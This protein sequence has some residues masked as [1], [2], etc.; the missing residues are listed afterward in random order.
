MARV[1]VVGGGFGG[2]RVVHELQ[3]S[4][5]PVEITLVDRKSYFEV[6]YATLRTLTNPSFAGGTQRKAFDEF[7]QASFIQGEVTALVDQSATLA[8]G[9]EIP[10][11]FAVIATGTSYPSLP[12]AKSETALTLET[13]IAE[14]DTHHQCLEGYRQIQIVGAGAVGTELAAEIRA[15][16]PDKQVRLLD[17]GDRVLSHLQPKASA[18]AHQML[19][20]LG[21]DVRLNTKADRS[22]DAGDEHTYWCGGPKVQTGF[23]DGLSARRD[24]GLMKVD[25]YLRVTGHDNWFAVG[26]IVDLPDAKMGA[27]ASNQGQSVAGNLQRLLSVKK[28]LKPYK[29]QP[30]MSIV[31]IG[32]MK[33]VAQIGRFVSTLKP[34]INFKQKDLLIQYA[35]SQI[36]AA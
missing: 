27:T 11:D 23:L 13:R 4:K 14:I 19:I 7:L 12:A 25:S 36:G 20:A 6:T 15:R 2:L 29:P 21:V 16:Y 9:Q 30:F 28:Q 22:L 24:D 32:Q 26:D 8:D 18:K 34:V 35:L 31:P 5:C 33:G 3:R 17:M 10:F 1:L